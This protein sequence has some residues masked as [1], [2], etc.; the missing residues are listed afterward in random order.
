MQS[1][2][3]GI[4]DFSETGLLSGAFVLLSTLVYY[5]LLSRTLTK[6]H[7]PSWTGSVVSL[8]YLASSIGCFW[9]IE[10]APA[11]SMAAWLVLLACSYLL[12]RHFKRSP[13]RLG[14]AVSVCCL[15][16]LALMLFPAAFFDSGARLCFLVFAGFAAGFYFLRSVIYTRNRDGIVYAAI[17]MLVCHIIDG[18]MSGF[19]RED[20]AAVAFMTAFALFILF[21]PS[22]KKPAVLFDLDGTLIDSQPLVFETFRRVFKEL[23]P[24]Y[25]LSED[26]LYS[27]FGPTL[28]VTFS[29]YFP[30][31]QV[32]SVIERYQEINLSLHDEMVK[33]IRHSRELLKALKD[34]GYKV[35]IVSNKRKKVV[36]KGAALAG[37]DEYADVIMGK[38]DQPKPKPEADGL[39]EACRKLDTSIDEV[40]YVGDNPAD[41]KA[42]RNLG[43]FSVGFTIDPRQKIAVLKENPCYF[44]EDLMD[45]TTLVKEEHTWNDPAIW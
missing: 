6:W 12:A 39:I 28:E 44:A 31:D 9:F 4:A 1:L 16:A 19:S 30:Q 33:P 32:E 15:P 25:D 5:F 18:M 37:L 21:I 2:L 14:D 36:L 8:V 13:L 24:E 35:G 43:G 45:I 26:E 20:F 17:A 42:A 38:E 29:R 10:S 7:Y 22:A 27:F 11:A 40:I 34:E 23:K 41:I 3:H